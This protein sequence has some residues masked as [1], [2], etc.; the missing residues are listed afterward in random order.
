MKEDSMDLVLAKAYEA[1]AAVLVAVERWDAPSPCVEWTV[2]EVA[3]HLVG[4]MAAFAAAIDGG[5]A[6]EY[7]GDDPA[8]AYAAA[9]ERCRVAF[10]RPGALS[11]AHPFPFGP[12]P[13]EVI[14]RISVSESLVHGWDIARGAG[15]AY[16]PAPEV[17]AAVLSAP[18]VAPEGM[19]VPVEPPPGADDMT[20][21]LAR[22]GRVA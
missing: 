10:G 5:P 3:N 14:A 12:T 13:G 4:A 19:Y 9:A 11:A 21:L 18:G 8:G 6:D 15:V 17:V 20:V 16:A 7:T 22:V 1:T 2:R